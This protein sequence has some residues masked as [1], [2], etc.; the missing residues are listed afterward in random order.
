MKLNSKNIIKLGGGVSLIL[1]AA[2]ALAYIFAY[3]NSYDPAIRHFAA[4]EPLATVFAVLF[5]ISAVAATVTAFMLRKR[6]NLRDTA[7]NQI[8]TFVLWFVSFL[9]LAIA[10]LY[11]TSAQPGTLENET[12]TAGFLAGFK[13]SVKEAFS[14]ANGSPM[15]L[16]AVAGVLVVPF[17]FLSA[18][19]FAMS[20]TSLR[21]STVHCIFTF[22][23]VLWGALLLFKFYFDL[24]EMPLNDPELTL[25]LVSISAMITLFISES[26]TSLGINTPA[27]SAFGC[28]LGAGLGG[29][30]ALARII[31]NLTAGHYVPSLMENIIFFSVGVLALVR[32]LS[33]GEKLPVKSSEDAPSLYDAAED[34]TPADQ[35]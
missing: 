35:L 12:S 21:S 33:I 5:A 7:P 17:A 27:I 18:I 1:A 4:G 22:A 26:R 3:K 11:V 30:V 28:I 10:F 8:E 16:G 19:A 14:P 23:P 20:A 24:T 34:V 9:F 15:N 2:A 25:T 32:F 31:L 13:T 29:C 6:G